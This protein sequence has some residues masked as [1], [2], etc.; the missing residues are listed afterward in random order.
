VRDQVVARDAALFLDGIAAN[1]E[2]LVAMGELAAPPALADFIDSSFLAD[3][4][5]K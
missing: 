3:A 1:I 2:A 5:R 4:A